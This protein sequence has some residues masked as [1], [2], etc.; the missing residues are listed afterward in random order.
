M[1]CVGVN[2][3]MGFI[4]DRQMHLIGTRHGQGATDQFAIIFDDNCTPVPKH[5]VY[6]HPVK[7]FVI[8]LKNKGFGTFMD[9]RFGGQYDLIV[10]RLI[11]WYF[12]FHT[13]PW[14]EVPCHKSVATVTFVAN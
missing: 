3:S 8:L 10:E 2:S 11:Q 6:G 12:Y 5:Y 4:F 7:V 9:D 13:L 14:S 1:P